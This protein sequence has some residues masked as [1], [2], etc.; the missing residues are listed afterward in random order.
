MDVPRETVQESGPPSGARDPRSP[1]SLLIGEGIPAM[2]PGDLRP[3][4][5]QANRKQENKSPDQ[6]SSGTA[7]RAARLIFKL[8]TAAEW[9]MT[10]LPCLLPISTAAGPVGRTLSFIPAFK[11][12]DAATAVMG[13]SLRDLSPQT[14]LGERASRPREPATWRSGAVQQCQARHH[15]PE[16]D[17]PNRSHRTVASPHGNPSR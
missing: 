5:N 17:P 9:T 15:V 2:F 3:H 7:L 13:G 16:T 6:L 11:V 12:R 1:P 10:L 8:H 4:R 14:V